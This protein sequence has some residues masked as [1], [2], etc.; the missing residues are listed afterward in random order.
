METRLRKLLQSMPFTS[1]RDSEIGKTMNES[2]LIP[3]IV[4]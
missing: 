2:T 1:F 3:G 4:A